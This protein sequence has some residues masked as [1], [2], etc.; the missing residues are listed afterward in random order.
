MVDETAR[1]LLHGPVPS[2][3]GLGI[4]LYQVARHAQAC[5]FSLALAHNA[6]GRVSFVLSGALNPIAESPAAPPPRGL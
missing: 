6:E 3:G 1:E 4:G 2:D 5:G